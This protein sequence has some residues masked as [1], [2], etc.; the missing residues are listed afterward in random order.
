[1]PRVTARKLAN[2][3]LP[4]KRDSGAS[5]RLGTQ[6]ERGLRRETRINRVFYAGRPRRHVET[7]LGFDSFVIRLAALPPVEQR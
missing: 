7:L 4:P 6:D 3:A 2:V 1:M 5:V